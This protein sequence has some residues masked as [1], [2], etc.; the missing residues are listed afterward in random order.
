MENLAKLANHMARRYHAKTYWRDEL[1]DLRQEAQ[2]AALE[3]QRTWRPTGAPL[4]KH[5]MMTMIYALR[6]Y[7]YRTE[8][9][10]TGRVGYEHEVKAVG[11]PLE[12]SPVERWAFDPQAEHT[13]LAWREAIFAKVER[14]LAE[15]D[16]SGACARVLLDN[17]PCNE[18]AKEVGVRP[19]VLRYKLATVRKAIREDEDLREIFKGC[20]KRKIC[21]TRG[22]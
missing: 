3:A 12:D 15:H 6:R 20:N 17:K 1:D 11:V 4:E 2:L 18:V 16:P 10:V 19:G 22:G 7:L 21:Y 8:L 5:A 13:A 14:V 9:P